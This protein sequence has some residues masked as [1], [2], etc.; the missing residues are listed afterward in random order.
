[1]NARN[2]TTY[3]KSGGTYTFINMFPALNFYILVGTSTTGVTIVAIQAYILCILYYGP[4]NK[5]KL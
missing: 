1:M 5:V 4:P 2:K 3:S